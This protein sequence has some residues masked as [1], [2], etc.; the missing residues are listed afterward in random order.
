MALSYIGGGGGIGIAIGGQQ[1][2][3]AAAA[4]ASQHAHIAGSMVVTSVAEP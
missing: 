1:L 2:V 3:A 4:I